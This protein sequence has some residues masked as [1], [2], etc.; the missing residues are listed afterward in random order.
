MRR[1]S[2]SG[3]ADPARFARD[4]ARHGVVVHNA[5][6]VFLDDVAVAVHMC[7]PIFEEHEER[8]RTKT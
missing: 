4:V 1:D 3:V 5:E 8:L 2:G 6:V 7:V